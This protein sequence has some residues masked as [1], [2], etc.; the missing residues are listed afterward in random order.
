MSLT[1][2]S[3]DSSS[4]ARLA[5]SPLVA[6]RKGYDSISRIDPMSLQIE[7]SSSTTR[8]LGLLILSPT[9]AALTERRYSSVR[10]PQREHRAFTYL[11]FHYNVAP[12]PHC[13]FFCERQSE[14]EPALFPGLLVSPAVKLF[15]NSGCLVR[16]N[17]EPLVGHLESNPVIAVRE[18]HPHCR[19]RG[20]VLDRIRDQ[21]HQRLIKQQPVRSNA[22]FAGGRHLNGNLLLCGHRPDRVEHVAENGCHFKIGFGDLLTSR[23]D[24]RYVQ[25]RLNEL[26]QPLALIDDRAEKRFAL[27][28]DHVVLEQ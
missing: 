7:R 8:I 23:L 12:M 9:V 18:T 25:K 5:C 15:E 13:D 26:I 20:A 4:I 1:R 19:A 27:L 3:K 17:A 28:L 22:H 21:I 16:R 11:T 10:Y 2:M 14:T 24:I 6:R